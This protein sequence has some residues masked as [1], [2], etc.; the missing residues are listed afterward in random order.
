M[1][2]INIINRILNKSLIQSINTSTSQ[3]DI[4]FLDKEFF[5]SKKEIIKLEK[6]LCMQ[7]DSISTYGTSGISLIFVKK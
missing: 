5:L 6:M 3:I 1:Q 4:N 7:L 2:T